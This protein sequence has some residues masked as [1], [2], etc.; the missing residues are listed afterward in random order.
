MVICPYSPVFAIEETPNVRMQLTGEA[1]AGLYEP[2]S[3]EGV[4]HPPSKLQY[5]PDVVGLIGFVSVAPG[6]TYSQRLLLNEWYDFSTPGTYT[7]QLIT[8][9]PYGDPS[10]IMFTIGAKNEQHLRGSVHGPDRPGPFLRPTSG[11][12]VR[13]RARPEQHPGPDCPTVLAANSRIRLICGE[14]CSR[15]PRPSGTLRSFRC[16]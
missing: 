2:V 8:H 5:D 9:L 15:R 11:R 7:V 13:C 1:G 6:E 16:L 12:T 4:V 10:P 3:P 14:R